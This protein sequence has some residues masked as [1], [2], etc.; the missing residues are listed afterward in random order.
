MTIEQSFF[1]KVLSDHLN[2]KY[3]SEP[4][5][6]IDWRMI[7]HLAQIHQVEGIIFHQCKDFLPDELKPYLYDK[8]CSTLSNY[9]NREYLINQLI[10]ALLSESIDCFIIKGV[11]VANL[12]PFPALRTM[13]DTD[14]VVH[15]EDR[16][17]VHEILLTQGYDIKSQ[18]ED[19][20]WIYYK[21]KYEF[22]LH[23]R[24]IYSEAINRDSHEEFFMDFWD[25]VHNGELDWNFHFLFLVLHLRK[26]LM[27]S[28]VG[29]RQFMDIAVLT[30]NND[31]LD[32]DYIEEKLIELDLIKFA[33][34]VFALNEV[35]FEIKTPIKTETLEDSFYQQA[36]DHVFSNG[37]FG[38][39]NAENKDNV[40]INNARKSKNQKA[41]MLKSAILKVFPSYENLIA[42]PKY[43]FLKGK[44]WL[45]P[46]A[47]IY[48][49]FHSLNRRKFA[50]NVNT[51]K[52]SF[53][54]NESIEKRTEWLKKWGLEEVDSN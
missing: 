44:K 22:E 30:K 11:T 54:S 33:R 32:W 26:H 29:F 18:F 34:I 20:E 40:S 6:I 39:D 36:T 14:L 13:G 15:T 8:Y 9:A 53:V 1:L 51:V 31:S 17:K 25:Y 2:N 41:G 42:V 49:I 27:N 37:V 12:Y 3:T 45:L 48:R 21:G 35:W 16:K 38:F 28:G 7:L 19:R 43:S 24:L 47:W 23:D 52:S 50:N 5:T 46:W 10:N 4:S